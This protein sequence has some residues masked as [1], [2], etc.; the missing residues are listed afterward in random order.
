[1]PPVDMSAPSSHEEITHCSVRTGP[2]RAAVAVVEIVGRRAASLLDRLFQ[3]AGPN[4]IRAGQVRF[5]NWV[6]PD[7]AV[8]PESVVVVP[9]AEQR[10]E[11]HCHGGVAAPQRVVS[12]LQQL[13]A[14]PRT[15]LADSLLVDHDPLRIEAADCLTR[16]TTTTTAAIALDQVR[17][18]LVDWR[19]AAL[20]R[21]SEASAAG[22]AGMAAGASE[23]A[24]GAAEIASQAAEIAARYRIGARLEA[25]WQVVLAG[26]ANVGKSTLLNALVGYD[27]SITLDHP[28][29]TRDVL[30]AETVVDGWPI[31]F[32]DTA[33]IRAGDSGIEREGIRRA[34]EAARRA[35]LVIVVYQGGKTHSA[36]NTAA[37]AAAATDAKAAEP[38]AAGD[39]PDERAFWRSISDRPLLRVCNKA[40]LGPPPVPIDLATVATTGRGIRELLSRVVDEL[41][42]DPPQPGWPIPVNDPQ[43]RWLRAIA[44]SSDDPDAMLRLL[45][46]AGYRP[47]GGDSATR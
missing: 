28:G 17:G 44:E 15:T 43:R 8:P 10:F 2:G 11:V 23:I 35:D 3:P 39:G 29:T 4:P 13:G 21:L 27:R 6:G 46:P 20:R 31:R 12:D 14:V 1:M 47:A 30:D 33:G 41:V 9:V 32:R 25:S 38:F 34:T 22:A 42:G 5:G 19:H 26:R 16:C 7:D 18:A 36:A 40:D 24:A 37:R 45:G